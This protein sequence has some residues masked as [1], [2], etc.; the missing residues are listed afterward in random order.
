M[1]RILTLLAVNVLLSLL[2]ACVSTEQ[3]AGCSKSGR[4][5]VEGVTTGSGVD[6]KRVTAW[7]TT[8]PQGTSY[9]QETSTPLGGELAKIAVGSVLPAVINA[10]AGLAIANK[11]TCGGNGCSAGAGTQINVVASSGSTAVNH[12]EGTIQVNGLCPNQPGGVCPLGAGM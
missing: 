1:N 10:G 8:T 3:F 11:Q 9:A 6:G 7:G 12:S 5:C 2:G 4:V